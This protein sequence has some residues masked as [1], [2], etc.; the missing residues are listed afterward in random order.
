MFFIYST[1]YLHQFLHLFLVREQLFQ[2]LLNFIRCDTHRPVIVLKD[3]FHERPICILAEDDTNG[4]VLPLE[5]F[6]II[7]DM[8]IMGK[9]AQVDWL[10]RT[11]LKFNHNKRPKNTIKEEQVHPVV[12]SKFVEV[13]LIPSI[14]ESLAE[15]HDEIFD[16]MNNL[17]F[18]DLLVNVFLANTKLLYIQIIQKIFI[19]K[20][21]NSPEGL[22][23]FWDGGN[24]VVR[25]LP[26]VVKDIFCD[27]SL[28][29]FYRKLLVITQLNVKLSLLNG[30]HARQNCSMMCKANIQK[31]SNREINIIRQLQLMNF[32]FLI[33]RY[34]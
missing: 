29:I 4:R 3:V 27:S 34:L 16:V 20:H 32:R 23:V 21:L 14:S 11:F 33:I 8:K 12:M 24:E 5:S 25:H 17:I 22:F 31:S 30:F 2:L 15:G 28:E 19:L 6:I 9:L 13:D 26:L 18:N 7:K 10:E 1:W